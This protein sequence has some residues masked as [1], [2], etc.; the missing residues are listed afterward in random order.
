[1]SY[2]A[3]L[4][5][6]AILF[7]A[8]SFSQGNNIKT[9]A[10]PIGYTSTSIFVSN[11]MYGVLGDDGDILIPPKYDYI[12]P[13]SF[14]DPS[15]A[16]V[17]KNNNCGVLGP[18]G[19]EVIPIKYDQISYRYPFLLVVLNGK[20]GMFDRDWRERIRPAKYDWISPFKADRAIVQ[21]GDK[22]GVVDAWGR[23][24]A[25]IKYDN[26]V[27][28]AGKVFLGVLGDSYY[29]LTPEG[30]TN[31]LK[32]LHAR[33]C[34]DGAYVYEQDGKW[35]VVDKSGKETVRPLYDLAAPY[36]DLIIVKR[37]E[38]YGAIDVNGKVLI[39][40]IYYVVGY[41]DV[42]N[43]FRAKREDYPAHYMEAQTITNKDGWFVGFKTNGGIDYFDF[44]GRNI[45]E[46]GTKRIK[47]LY[48]QRKKQDRY[49][50]NGFLI[51][52]EEIEY[53]GWLSPNDGWYLTDA[54]LRP[55]GEKWKSLRVLHSSKNK[56]DRV[57]AAEA[58]HQYYILGDKGEV[59]SGPYDQIMR[60]TLDAW[61][62][63]RNGVYE[64]VDR[65][66]KSV[67]PIRSTLYIEHAGG[68]VYL[69]RIE[70]TRF[71]NRYVI[72]NIKG[73]VL[74][75]ENRGK[76]RVQWSEERAWR[77]VGDKYGALD[78]AG[79]FIIA[80]QYDEVEPFSN[81]LAL[82]RPSDSIPEYKV[83][84]RDGRIV[85]QVPDGWEPIDKCYN[86]GM[87]QFRDAN[88]NRV[89][90]NRLGETVFS[91]DPK[92]YADTVGHFSSLGLLKVQSAETGLWGF[93]SKRGRV[94]YPC[95]FSEASDYQWDS[96]HGLY[97]ATVKEEG[98]DTLYYMDSEGNM[99]YDFYPCALIP[100]LTRR[101]LYESLDPD[102]LLFFSEQLPEEYYNSDYDFAR[103]VEDR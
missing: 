32:S 37:D 22:Y 99:I 74:S 5:L 18:D 70:E 3:L 39:P 10:A 63:Q 85:F 50:L 90:V 62:V 29:I 43:S 83:I 57:F 21:V 55:I 6:T 72:K 97:Y 25:K 51:D 96:L 34:Q 95:T 77:L 87:M 41:D 35:G 58:N 27:R 20:W 23:E 33:Q 54:N 48:K 38:K 1:M 31:P 103:E 64:I 28:L 82:V 102:T 80:P 16:K 4:F 73:E 40:L 59:L 52:I 79:T 100:D 47:N 67:S 78:R 65:Y 68:Q 81:G 17:Y 15:F 71:A 98:Q 44:S 88:G 91:L 89:F 45:G 86:N 14:E 84:G 30:K 61:V 75:D 13:C 8:V 42:H 56:D 26:I 92:E 2:R 36:G 7:P 12:E 46:S 101:L 11:G 24:M 66:G 76:P 60:G 49:K 19:T 9:T 69:E 53:E 94:I 93:L